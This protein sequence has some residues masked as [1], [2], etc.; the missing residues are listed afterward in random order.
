[1][2]KLRL[3][4]YFRKLRSLNNDTIGNPYFRRRDGRHPLVLLWINIRLAALLVE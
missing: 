4:G 2:K 3:K 1:M